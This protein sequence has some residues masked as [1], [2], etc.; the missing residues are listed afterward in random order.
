MGRRQ[1]SLLVF[2]ESFFVSVVD[3]FNLKFLSS[4]LELFILLFLF[5]CQ[6]SSR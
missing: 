3:F 4:S 1:I 2:L 5:S 6:I